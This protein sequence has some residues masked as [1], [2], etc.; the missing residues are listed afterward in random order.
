MSVN[1]FTEEAVVAES[2]VYGIFPSV[3]TCIERITLLWGCSSSLL[4]SEHDGQWWHGIF[5]NKQKN[6]FALSG[7]AHLLSAAAS[8]A[9]LFWH[10]FPIKT[11]GS[12]WQEECWS[13]PLVFQS[14]HKFFFL[15]A[16]K[17]HFHAARIP[18]SNYS[19]SSTA[20]LIIWWT[21]VSWSRFFQLFKETL[22]TQLCSIYIHKINNPFL[23]T[24]AMSA[25]NTTEVWR[26]AVEV[27]FF[28]VNS[29]ERYSG[30]PC[31]DWATKTCEWKQNVATGICCWNVLSFMPYLEGPRIFFP[32][33]SI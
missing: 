26:G 8:N 24:T 14:S 17:G 29:P 21:T 25:L 7:L 6:R 13:R 23:I 2:P 19:R 33:V 18:L 9:V 1:S 5:G 3:H 30:D 32:R 27:F 20:S 28:T 16:P 12:Y 31:K 15:W 10:V 4:P 22:S 11:Q